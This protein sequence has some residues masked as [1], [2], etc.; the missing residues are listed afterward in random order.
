MWLPVGGSNN[1]DATGG[2]PFLVG[3]AN[4][5]GAVDVGD[6]NIWNG[7]KFSAA[8]GWCSGDFNA[9]GSVDVSDFNS[10]NGNKFQSS[11]AMLVPEPQ[12]GLIMGLMLWLMAVIGWCRRR[13]NSI[14]T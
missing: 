1:S 3:D 5:D 13:A 11:D 9:D 10:W 14:G 6:F 12:M 8:P 2:S 4:L 7:N